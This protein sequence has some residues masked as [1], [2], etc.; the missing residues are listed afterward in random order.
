M[1]EI[2]QLTNQWKDKDPK[3][4]VW[5]TVEIKYQLVPQKPVWTK[6]EV[7]KIEERDQ[8]LWWR[9]WRYS[10]NWYWEEHLV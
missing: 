6:F 5:D 10:Y 1:K 4:K 7:T 8:W 2:E 3:Y 9:W